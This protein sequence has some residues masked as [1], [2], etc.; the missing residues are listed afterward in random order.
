MNLCAAFSLKCTLREF[1]IQFFPNQCVL[2][3]F[4]KLNILLLCYLERKVHYLSPLSIYKRC[5][6]YTNDG[7]SLNSTIASLEG[8]HNI[9]YGTCRQLAQGRQA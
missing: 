6:I 8:D 7:D 9:S 3:N 1:Y 4:I 2:Y 5:S